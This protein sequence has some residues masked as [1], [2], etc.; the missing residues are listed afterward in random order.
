MSVLLLF[1]VGAAGEVFAGD[2][3]KPLKPQPVLSPE[4]AAQMAALA[5]EKASRTAAQKKLDS[6]IVLAIKKSRKEAPFDKYPELPADLAV[7]PDGR[8]LVDMDATVTKELLAHV[9]DLGGEVISSFP[10]MRAI[11]ALV[12]LTRLEELAGRADMKFISPASL[13]MTNS[14]GN[15]SATTGNSRSASEPAKPSSTKR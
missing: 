2:E 11:R 6:H 12:P 7:Q 3:P 4:V 14:V 15:N 10:D 8:V 1:F 5:K 13:P 9:A